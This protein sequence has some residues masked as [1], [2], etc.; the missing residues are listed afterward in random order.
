MR[1]F[2][3]RS[4]NFFV[5]VGLFSFATNIL[6]LA[7]P[8]YF[9]QVFDRVMTSQS[10]ATLLVLTLGIGV[11]LIAMSLFEAIRASMLAR[12]GQ[13]MDR[14]V[15]TGVV[16]A[17]LHTASR[18]PFRFTYRTG[19]KDVGTMRQFISGNPVI[20]FFDAPWAPINIGIISM[21][22][23]RLG[24]LATVGILILFVL[25]IIEDRLTRPWV[26]E[27]LEIAQDA[28][29]LVG[30]AMRNGEVV[31]TQGMIAP[32][33]ARWRVRSDEG[34]AKQMSAHRR[35][36]VI[37]AMTKAV[38]YGIQVLM[39]ALGVY[40]VIRQ[41]ATPGVIL[42]STLILSR[43]MAP[44]EQVIA[45][46]K[47]FVEAKG[48]Y[49]RLHDFMVQVGEPAEP[50][51]LPEPTGRLTV[52]RV[53]M[54]GR[55]NVAILKNIHFELK[56]GDSLAVVGPSGAGKS[57]LARVLVGAWQPVSGAVRLDGADLAKSDPAWAGRNLGYL[58][59]QVELLPGTIAE[60]IAR[61]GDAKEH[62]E[63]VVAAAIKAGAHDMILRLPKGYDTVVGEGG[64]TLSGGQNQRVGFARALFGNPKVVVL[65]EPNASLDTEGEAALIGALRILKGEGVTLIVIAHRPS[66]LADMELALVLKDGAM[67]LMGPR[68]DVFARLA[69]PQPAVT[70]VT[71]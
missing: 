45:S 59:Q 13:A 52:E 26:E 4:R 34:L 56:P 49:R 3:S 8:I 32:M 22:D 41:E 53:S 48:A 60:N 71:A 11:V 16:H 31:G 58:P 17:T 69:T 61:M 9:M 28:G 44:M 38:R 47:M 46:W 62:A 54:A 15:G 30:S 6:Q 25:A 18:Q 68:Q 50:M 43:A 19:L 42:A 55:D 66:L 39:M 64:M 67:Q 27:S 21:F 70:G 2:L 40:L 57:C 36:V 1:K 14:M 20:A 63:A 7:I 37:N 65:D 35:S 24:V 5:F 12:I 51:P 29:R 23:W 33:V 10:E